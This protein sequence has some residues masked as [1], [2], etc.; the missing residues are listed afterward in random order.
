MRCFEITGI[1]EKKGERIKKEFYRLTS[2]IGKGY[3]RN[4]NINTCIGLL[5]A[6]RCSRHLY[7]LC[8]ESKN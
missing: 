5:C 1:Y 2:G 7:G 8:E 6:R 3:F 4:R